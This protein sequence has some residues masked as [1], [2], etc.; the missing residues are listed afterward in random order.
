MD[1][2][3]D[4]VIMGLETEMSCYMYCVTG[5]LH[6]I[7][8]HSDDLGTDLAVNH[9]QLSVIICQLL[10]DKA[11]VEVIAR[12][13]EIV[14]THM[15]YNNNYNN[16]A[17]TTTTTTTTTTQLLCA[18]SDIVHNAEY[19]VRVISLLITSSLWSESQWSPDTAAPPRMSFLPCLSVHLRS[20]G[21]P[22]IGR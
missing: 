13:L 10:I 2:H 4:E 6:Y 19:H 14:P 20:R 21:A 1:Q 12:T 8:A 9:R 18:C 22:I 17:T 16:Y 7:S 5:T 15:A 11:G 3:R